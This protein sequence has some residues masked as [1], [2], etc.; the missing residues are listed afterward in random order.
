MKNKIIIN[1][2]FAFIIFLFSCKKDSV[3]PSVTANGFITFK[4]TH[5]I[6][7]DSLIKSSMIY[8]NQAGNPYEINE[9]KYFISDLVLY[10]HNADPLIL[11][12]SKNYHYVDIDIAQTLKWEISD[13][14]PSLQYDSI[15][16]IFGLNEQRNISNTFINPPESNMFWPEILG[17]GY[18]YMMI[19]GKWKTPTNQIKSFNLHMG[20]GQIYSG[21]TTSTD[22]IIGYIPNFFKVNIATPSLKVNASQTTILQLNMNINSW[23]ETPHIYNHNIWGGMIMQ[24]QAA[25]QTVKENG[26]DVFSLKY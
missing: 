9:V 20:I 19:N 7:N 25:M 22:S 12:Y 23:F 2:M 17:G 4:F 10:P 13:K 14:I 15:G 3:N 21:T 24:N 5:S 16:F 11:N 1:L 6:G 8:Q 18:H 26:F